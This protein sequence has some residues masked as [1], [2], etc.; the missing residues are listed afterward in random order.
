MDSPILLQQK[1]SIWALSNI[2]AGSRKNVETLILSNAYKKIIEKIKNLS[3]IT[4]EI[5]LECVWTISNTI[6]GCDI[7]LCIKLIDLDIIQIL[8]HVFDKIENEVILLVALNGL[9][10]LF[11]FG[12]PMKQ[13]C[14]GEGNVKNP[15]V[16]KFCYYGGHCQ[17]EKLQNHKVSEV[18]NKTEEI[19]RQYFNFEDYEAVEIDYQNNDNANEEKK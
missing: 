3:K 17:L 13:F 14:L 8:I 15:I 19:V 18:Y 4:L 10:S 6:S 9:S 7:E 1:E 2:A 5:L 12:E 16:E 11:K